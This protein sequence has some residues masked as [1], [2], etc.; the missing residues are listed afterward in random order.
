MLAAPTT[1]TAPPASPTLV[2]IAPNPRPPSASLLAAWGRA[3]RLGRPDRAAECRRRL[4]ALS[5]EEPGWEDAA[6]Q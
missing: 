6:W 1:T 2:H 3:L 5:D 4:E